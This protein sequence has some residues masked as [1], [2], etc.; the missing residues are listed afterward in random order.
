MQAK[1]ILVSFPQLGAQ[2]YPT[3]IMD[4]ATVDAAANMSQELPPII[5]GYVAGT[6]QNAALARGGIQSPLD[7]EFDAHGIRQLVYYIY[8]IY[9]YYIYILGWRS[10]GNSSRR[11]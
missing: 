1:D 4:E 11:R 8:Y 9:I 3:G 7:G 5:S 2:L 6:A 10:G